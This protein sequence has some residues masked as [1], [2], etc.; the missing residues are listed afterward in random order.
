MNFNL[1][2]FLVI[3]ALITFVVLNA[4]ADIKIFRYGDQVTGHTSDTSQKSKLVII[5]GVHGNEPAGTYT[6]L[7]MIKEGYFDKPNITQKYKQIVV[8]PAVN[9]WGLKNSTRY[10]ANPILPDINR[11]FS[12][13]GASGKIPNQLVKEIKDADLVL[14][15]HEGWGY[16]REGLG[17]I[18]SSISPSSLVKD[19]SIVKKIQDNLNKNIKDPIKKFSIINKN[20]SD[21]SDKMLS[22]Y[23]EAKKIPYILIETTGQNDIQPI[24]VRE[25]QIK[26]IINTVL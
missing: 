25:G 7:N 22:A 15:F 18:G 6:L 13:N 9:E 5:A 21:E 1:G 26:T 8:I 17:S 2:I 14:D 20:P 3:T 10:T 11:S 12:E 23:A 4:N 16:Y 19:K 24:N